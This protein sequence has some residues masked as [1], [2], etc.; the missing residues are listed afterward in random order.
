M[1]RMHDDPH[2][3]V[4]R[5]IREHASALLRTARRHSLCA[6]DAHDAYQ[7]ALEIFLRRA[8]TLEPDTA[9]RWLHV[10]V[11]NEAKAVRR[12]R[13]QLVGPEEPNLDARVA[14][15]LPDA[16]ER[17]LRFDRLSRSAEALARLKP[18]EV[19]ALWLK[20]QG[21]SYAE[22]AESE[23]WTYT[24]VNRCIT[25]GRR[26]FLDR[27]A[28][29]ES[30]AECERWSPVVSAMVDGE[31]TA[32]QL[33]AARPHLR[34]C[35]ACRS[36]VR[37]LH[38][39]GPRLAGVLPVGL[40]AVGAGADASVATGG[41]PLEA[42]VRAAE[43]AAGFVQ[44]RAAAV[45]LKV[46]L[47]TEAA[48]ATKV[49]AVAA[50]TVAIAGGGMA[51][52]EVATSTR[53]PE[54]DVAVL[55]RPADAQGPVS[56]AAA[57][58]AG[59]VGVDPAGLMVGPGDAGAEPPAE[60]GSDGAGSGEPTGEA[61]LL[62]G[63]V[64]GGAGELARVS[65]ESGPSVSPES[66]SRV[67]SAVV[68]GPGSRPAGTASVEPRGALATPEP[69]EAGSSGSAAASGAGASGSTAESAEPERPAATADAHPPSSSG[70]AASFVEPR[71]SGGRG[72][73]A[74]E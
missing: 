22:I 25:E 6:D 50:S 34:R 12:S 72:E 43:G 73:F 37:E 36:T 71:R 38:A 14:D 15:A 2:D 62:G 8:S 3:L 9:V 70:T 39:A 52:Q 20:A 65:V 51:V 24:K 44:E 40:V 27:Y 58:V 66:F 61:G 31:A 56:Q 68:E 7:R 64:E 57:G 63:S 49:A 59:A 42:I 23:G 1:G 45:A 33:A 5:T 21:H 41:G 67:T 11:K 32:E 16:D 28:G 35:A 55:S 69:S 74:R 26:A 46:Q 17:V 48:T 30:G 13:Q 47:A 18:Q 60:F 29:I 4:V 54:R 10:V 53:E 19:R